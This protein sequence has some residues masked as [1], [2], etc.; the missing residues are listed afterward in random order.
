MNLSHTFERQNTE[1]SIIFIEFHKYSLQ[2]NP[3]WNL[4]N[5]EIYS[6]CMGFL[7]VCTGK[8]NSTAYQ[9][10]KL[11]FF[12]T[13]SG[14]KISFENP[15][16]SW[17]SVGSRE[18]FKKILP[19][20]SEFSFLKSFFTMFIWS[21]SAFSHTQTYTYEWAI[22]IYEVDDFCFSQR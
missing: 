7:H 6:I 3:F 17:K 18:K 12:F 11:T 1:Q 20:V 5:Q 10:N 4:W 2:K 13:C 19:D 16:I 8:K 22:H 21:S 14:P 15:E 9:W